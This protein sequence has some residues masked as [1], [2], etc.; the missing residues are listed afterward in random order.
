QWGAGCSNGERTLKPKYNTKYA[1][2]RSIVIPQTASDCSALARRV[3]NTNRERFCI[4]ADNGHWGSS[5]PT[6]VL[7]AVVGKF[8]RSLFELPADK[9]LYPPYNSMSAFRVP[10]RNLEHKARRRRM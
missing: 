6:Y 7:L 9:S 1:G 10:L 8:P 4:G 2:G 5:H 3:S